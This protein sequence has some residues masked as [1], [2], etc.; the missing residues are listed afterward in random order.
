QPL[1][2]GVGGEQQTTFPELDDCR[3]SFFTRET[4]VKQCCVRRDTVAEMDK[5]VAIFREHDCGLSNAAKKPCER[6][7]FGFAP[8]GQ[9]CRL[10]D[11]RQQLALGASVPE[12]RNRPRRRVDCRV[13]FTARIENRQRQLLRNTPIVGVEGLEPMLDGSQERKGAR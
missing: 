4:T 12:R 2:G 11:T 9:P 10:S 3:S 7:Q 8:K 5:S 1:A 13:E 6:P